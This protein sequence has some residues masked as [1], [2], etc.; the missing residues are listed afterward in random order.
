MTLSALTDKSHEPTDDDVRAVLGKAHEVWTHL[1]DSVA[2][3]I[4]PVDQTWGF[5]SKSTGWGLRLRLKDRVILYMTPQTEKFLV[6]FAL[7]ERAVADAKLRK[8]SPTL[9]KAIDAAP[10]YAEGRGVRIEVTSGRQVA[11]L[12]A[13]AGIKSEN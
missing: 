1:I 4:G 8:L 6:S 7:G 13:L 12:A 9:L 3:R 10:R 11:A 2:E 5:T